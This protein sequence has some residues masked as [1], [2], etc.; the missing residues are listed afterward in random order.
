M[1]FDCSLY[2]ILVLYSKCF[3]NYDGIQENRVYFMYCVGVWVYKWFKIY[4]VV[5]FFF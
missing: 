4:V 2:F 3:E 1:R 5:F